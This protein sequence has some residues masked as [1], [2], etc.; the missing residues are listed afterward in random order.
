MKQ[1]SYMSLVTLFAL[2][3]AFNVSAQVNSVEV[4]LPFSGSEYQSDSLYFRAVQSGESS[5]KATSKKIAL[6]NAKSTLATT[7]EVYV[8]SAIESYMKENVVETEA[9]Y[10]S[11]YYEVSIQKAAQLLTNINV[12]GE[13]LYLDEQ[14]NYTT[15]IAIEIRRSAALNNLDVNNTEIDSLYGMENKGEILNKIF[16]LKDENR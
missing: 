8:S 2:L 14:G 11:G 3:Q 5:T 12:I 1:A 13:K 15:W 9:E 10:E 6:I 4:E 16:N 7:V